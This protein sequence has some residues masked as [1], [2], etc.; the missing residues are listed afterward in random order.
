MNCIFTR[1]IYLLTTKKALAS[2]LLILVFFDGFGQAQYTWQPV[3]GNN[4]S[5]AVNWL[6]IRIMPAT[7]DVLVFDGART[8][9]TSVTLDFIIAQ[10]IGQLIFVNS[11]QVAL[12]NDG[13]RTLNV[14]AVLPTIGLQVGTGAKLQLVGT[15]D[16][17][18]LKVQLAPNVKARIAGRIEL[19]GLGSSGSGHQLLSNTPGALEFL[20]GSYLLGGSKF[21]GFPFGELSAGA[22]SAVF[23]S[24]ATFEQFSGGT[25]FGAKPWSVA[26]FESGSLFLF[27]ATSGSIGLS[28]RTFGNLTINANR[29]APVASYGAS[30]TI[31]AN[32][33]T[34]AAGTHTFN[35]QNLDLQGNLLLNGGNLDFKSVDNSTN[36]VLNPT[37]LITLNGSAIQSIT[38]TG[39]ITLGP[40]V[41]LTLNNAA[42]LVLQRPLQI[43]ADLT[44][45]QGLLTTTAANRL[46]LVYPA[47]ATG[48]ATSFVNGPLGWVLAT[49]NTATD[50]FFSIGSGTVYRPL[51]LRAEQTDAIAT[52][53]TAQQFNQAPTVRAM[54]TA[55][56]SLQRASAVRYFNVTNG[57]ASNF[58]QGTITLNYDADDK[59]DAPAKLRIAKSDNAGNWLDL[60]GTG[61]GAPGGSITSAVA[62][63]SFSDFALAST[64]ATAGPGNNPLPVSLTRFTARREPAGVR[65]RWGTATERD[66]R[67]FEVLRST[68]G[69]VFSILKKVLGHGNS[70]SAQEYVWLDE[71]RDAN[72]LV[73]YRLHQVNTD[74]TGT[75]SSVVAV[76]ADV[77]V[78]G[79]FPNPVYDHLSF[80][81]ATGDTYRVLDVFGRPTLVGQA[82]IGL[83]TLA[84]NDLKTGAYYLEITNAQGRVRHRFVK[85]GTR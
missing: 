28:G 54:P 7:N 72:S 85:G 75:Y 71:T 69:Q 66:N 49:A 39:N 56:G 84:M 17:A 48:N 53:Y 18:A 41:S 80:Y 64:E 70:T 33:L 63:T 14:G 19:L 60:G 2:L 10:T 9:T 78:A 83:N 74:N 12:N 21:T 68:D 32:D 58:K 11:V 27:T 29:T 8:P 73:Y 65:L 6:P 40:N 4:W 50:M 38:G 3:A 76:Q 24:G 1:Q 22:G 43:S 81:A 25:A 42:G 82:M 31:I 77:V 47:N 23:R 5:N 46:T 44:L 36:P 20:S 45:T 26:T 35:V 55:A 61:S 52:T 15:T 62:F 79:M 16:N 37:T 34:V 67:H 57:G 13:P 59:V 51:T 30:K